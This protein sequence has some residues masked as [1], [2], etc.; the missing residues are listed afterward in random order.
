MHII[1]RKWLGHL[2]QWD[3][4]GIIRTWFNHNNQRVRIIKLM[5]LGSS[6][7]VLQGPQSRTFKIQ[8]LKHKHRTFRPNS[9]SFRFCNKITKKI[10]LH[11]SKSRTKWKIGNLNQSRL[12]IKNLTES[13]DVLQTQIKELLEIITKTDWK[14]MSIFYLLRFI[15]SGSHIGWVLH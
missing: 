12:W 4:I 10:W 5:V 8:I 7:S 6:S 15:N 11:L 14:F 1:C 9:R 2:H 3:K 13:K